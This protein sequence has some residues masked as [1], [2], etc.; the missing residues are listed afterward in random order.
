MFAKVVQIHRTIHKN[1]IK[2]PLS[3][4]YS[5]VTSVTNACYS[6]IICTFASQPDDAGT[7]PRSYIYL[8]NETIYIIRCGIQPRLQRN[9]TTYNSA[10]I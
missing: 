3:M 8:Y 9:N 10:Y 1:G 7:S 2:I 6:D 5:F 4:C